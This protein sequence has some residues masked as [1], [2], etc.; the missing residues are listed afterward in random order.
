MPKKTFLAIGECMI[1]M[2]RDASDGWKLG[3]AGDTLNTA[4]YFRRGTSPDAWSVD[5]FTR[6]GTDRQSDRI[7]DFIV[8]AGIGTGHIARDPSRQPG[9][10]LIDLDAGERSFTYWRGQ[11]A[12]RLL[13]DDEALLRAAIEASD[14][15][16][17][18]GITLAILAPGRRDFLLSLV[19]DARRAGRTTVFDPNVRPRLWEGPDEIRRR[20]RQA[21]AAASIVLPSFDDER[22]L[23]GDATPEA[24]AQRY[25]AAGSGEVVVKNGGGDL[26]IA[27]THGMQSLHVEDKVEPVDTTGAGDSFNGAYLARRLSGDEVLEAARRGHDVARK[28]VRHHGALVEEA[29]A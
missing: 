19:A 5:Y 4:W 11:S 13:A 25:L 10:Y 9:L 29:V 1:E 14:V 28:V 20:V 22:T 16:Y 6:L 7:C 8:A 21:A 2:A 3:V 24:C 17:F 15:V 23:F 27:D 12:A 18:S 26:C